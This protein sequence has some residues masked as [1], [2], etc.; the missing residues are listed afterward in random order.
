MALLAMCAAMG[1]AHSARRKP[2]S[3]SR[4]PAHDS[5]VIDA[6]QRTILPSESRKQTVALTVLKPIMPS[7]DSEQL[8]AEA[9]SFAV[10]ASGSDSALNK[11]VRSWLGQPT[12]TGSP[13]DPPKGW[14]IVAPI[15]EKP[16]TFAK[17]DFGHWDAATPGSFMP[18]SEL[19]NTMAENA[20]DAQ[21]AADSS[22]LSLLFAPAMWQNGPSPTLAPFIVEDP[23]ADVDCT[24]ELS[25]LQSRTR[26]STVF[27][28]HASSLLGSRRTSIHSTWPHD[29]LGMT[30]SSSAL[31]T[32]A[33]FSD[34]EKTSST[35]FA[36]YEV[37]VEVSAK[38]VI[39]SAR[40][41][42]TGP[43]VL[44]RSQAAKLLGTGHAF[45]QQ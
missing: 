19:F 11:V 3:P 35:A 20:S 38:I 30:R 15:S 7:D 14:L 28:D 24:S 37:E 5:R 44:D 10:N 26:A 13:Q 16:M 4:L 12:S 45:P 2:A 31:P 43:E 23:F 36:K 41:S 33:A 29:P 22:R 8:S 6:I 17:Q 1:Q 9:R 42:S 27:D 40:S 32:T 18:D 25:D 21:S 39:S 34:F